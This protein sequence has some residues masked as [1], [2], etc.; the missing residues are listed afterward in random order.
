VRR[1][2][3]AGGLRW[4]RRFAEAGVDGLLRD[5]TRK[6]GK[7]CL[8]DPTVGSADSRFHATS[9]TDALSYQMLLGSTQRLVF[10]ARPSQVP[11]EGSYP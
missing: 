4:Q 1:G 2:R 9:T 10:E 5:A 8:D 3:P 7:A 11:T 6:P